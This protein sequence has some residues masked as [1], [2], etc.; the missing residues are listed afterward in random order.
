[1]K[2]KEIIIIKKHQDTKATIQQRK[3]FYMLNRFRENSVQDVFV[4]KTSLIWKKT[5]RLKLTK[6]ELDTCTSY[7]L[8]YDMHSLS[9][10]HVSNQLLNKDFFRWPENMMPNESFAW[11]YVMRILFEMNK[12]V[13]K[14]MKKYVYICLTKNWK[15]FYY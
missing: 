4:L 11:S 14:F 10:Q 6:L 13:Y 15:W 8:I 2:I 12:K 3:S 1:M 5:S 7:L 9:T